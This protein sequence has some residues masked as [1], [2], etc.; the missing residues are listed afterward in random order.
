[1]GDKCGA[2]NDS[3]A[4]VRI[5]QNVRLEKVILTRFECMTVF[6]QCQNASHFDVTFSNIEH[7]LHL[8]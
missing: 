5:L 7:G 1:M 4:I 6:S 8:K 3:L 2:V